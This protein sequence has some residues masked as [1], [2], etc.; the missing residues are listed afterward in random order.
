MSN[1]HLSELR[2]IGLLKDTNVDI[3]NQVSS[4]IKPKRRR[5]RGRERRQSKLKQ[6]LLL[7]NQTPLSD[8][9]EVPP[10]PYTPRV[11]PPP[12]E[13]HSTPPREP[14]ITFG[15]FAHG[16]VD[17]I[18]LS[19]SASPLCR[20]VPPVN[21]QSDLLDSSGW[22]RMEDRDFSPTEDLNNKEPKTEV[23][24]D[25]S[26][27]EPERKFI[28]VKLYSTRVSLWEIAMK[29]EFLLTTFSEEDRYPLGMTLSNGEGGFKTYRYVRVDEEHYND[30]ILYSLGMSPTEHTSGVLRHYCGRKGYEY[31]ILP[32]VVFQQMLL[33]KMSDNVAGSSRNSIPLD[34]LNTVAPKYGM[35][36]YFARRIFLT[37]K[38]NWIMSLTV[39]SVVL[40]RNRKMLSSL[41]NLSYQTTIDIQNLRNTV[42]FLGRLLLI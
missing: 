1:L 39:G 7:K 8:I 33:M 37:I 4:V 3:I 26:G 31:F 16:E 40:I 14:R 34:S 12:L 25:D 18:L 5:I 23:A 15:D 30:L 11:P 20:N 21:P 27:S 38:S 6:D 35:L 32:S 13:I 24:N 28:T 19:R 17:D 22:V 36:D 42:R 9:P 29:R 2:E 10:P 41:V